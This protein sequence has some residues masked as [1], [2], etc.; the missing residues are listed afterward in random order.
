MS[1]DRTKC[2]ATPK[3]NKWNNGQFARMN[4]LR[5]RHYY[6]DGS[7]RRAIERRQLGLEA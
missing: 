4:L 3:Q 6:K 2:K 1:K 5:N 7:L